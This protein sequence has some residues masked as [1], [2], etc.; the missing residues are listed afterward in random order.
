MADINFDYHVQFFTATIIEEND[1]GLL[2]HY[3]G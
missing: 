1:F 2:T 3:A